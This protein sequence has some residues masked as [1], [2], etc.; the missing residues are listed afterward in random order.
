MRRLADLTH[1]RVHLS[2]LHGRE[3]LTILSESS[4]QMIEAVGWVGRTSPVHC[5]SAGRA[6]L[7]DHADEEIRRMLG[8]VDPTAPQPCAPIQVEALLGKL[9][10]D[11]AR[12]FRWSTGSSTATWPPRR[13]PYGTSAA[14][15]SPR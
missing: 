14:A 11:R 8:D 13:R 3:V 4:R 1:E 2:V 5:T 10:Q 6:P 7:F 15:S 12:G 9:N